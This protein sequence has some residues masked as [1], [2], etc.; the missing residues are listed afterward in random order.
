MGIKFLNIIKNYKCAL[1]ALFFFAQHSEQLQAAESYLAQKDVIEVSGFGRLVG[2]YLDDPDLEFQRYSDSISF[3]EQSLLGL[4]LDL[5]INDKL[6]I[7]TQGILHSSEDR[8]SEIQWLYLQYQATRSLSVRLGR[9]RMP[10]FDFSE[11]NDV[12]FAY[13]WI[14][15]PL[16]VYSNFLF[17]D[18]DG[19]MASYEFS[20]KGVSGA[21]EAYWGEFE[22]DLTVAETTAFTTVDNGHGLILKLNFDAFSFRASHHRTKI[23]IGLKPILEFKS[24]LSNVGLIESANSL[25]LAGQ[26]EFSQASL[27]YDSFDYFLK[28]EVTRY[29][30]DF[31]F[32]P[33]VNS[34][35]ITAGYNF[36]PFSMHFTYALSKESYILP[37]NSIPK[38]L[39]PQITALSFAFDQTLDNLNNYGLESTS[40]GVRYDWNENIALKAEITKLNGEATRG[41]FTRNSETNP[42]NKA[43][44]IQVAVEWVF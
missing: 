2:G 15:P 25:G 40:I 3:G 30:S 5:N 12:G 4:R 26:L 13:P 32:F 24:I 34:G 8:D 29:D 27:N 10:F 9:Q 16:Q 6:K 21:V 44:L 38:G 35:Y 18:I 11:T 17:F 39:A 41:L 20:S 43:N 42:K 7:V 14:T 37:N 28:A 19:A 1:L 36:Y 31:L 33:D 22:G 23:D